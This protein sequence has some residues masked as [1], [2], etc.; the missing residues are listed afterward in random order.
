[1]GKYKTLTGVIGDEGVRE[2]PYGL[3]YPSGNSKDLR[4]YLKFFELLKE[5]IFII[6]NKFEILYSN[7]FFCNLSGYGK[8]EIAGKKLTELITADK[9][10]NKTEVL[11]YLTGY[12]MWNK[13]T[14]IRNKYGTL[15][16]V[17]LSFHSLYYRNRN[18]RL[19]FCVCTDT[20]ELKTAID[21]LN[22]RND[23]LDLLNDVI[24]QT[25]RSMDLK[26]S[27]TYAI[28][29]VCQYTMWE[30]G[31]CF[32]VVN[33]KLV[34]TGIWNSDLNRKYSAFKKY[35]ERESYIPEKGMPRKC[36]Q[37]AKPLLYD[38]NK[39]K[40]GYPFIRFDYIRKYGLISG[41]WLPVLINKKVTGV[42]E[43]FSSSHIGSDNEILYGLKN[44]CLELGNLKERIETINGIKINEKLAA[45]GR[46]S[47]GIAHEIRNPL[48]NISALS[49]LL[50]KNENNE[51][52]KLYLNYIFENIQIANNTITDLLSNVSS[53]ELLLSEVDIRNF[54]E[55]IL[56]KT[57]LRFYKRKIQVL[58][59]ISSVLPP[60]YIDEIKMENAIMNF[61]TNALDSMPSGGR[62]KFKVHK[63]KQE[64]N[65]AII[66]ADS[67]VGIP[68]EN[69]EKIFEPFFTTKHYGTGLGMG[70]ALQAIKSHG[71]SL[72]IKSKQG[73]GTTI[74]IKIPLMKEN[75]SE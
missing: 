70:L 11:R 61:L 44:I 34:S 30:I 26:S 75:K 43:F 72:K 23:L 58:K 18:Q 14:G 69:M 37:R 27:V 12:G 13:E 32:L 22:K 71:G 9:P 33:D 29:K 68:E 8:N 6:N 35:T 45:L 28:D 65:I 24:K 57:R 67:G 15:K 38:L 46:F 39:L 54:I 60:V 2:F 62:I 40:K 25:N 56:S 21:L 20:T 53:D 41:V 50:L 49:Q 66:I 17:G 52:K 1:M 74:E 10:L 16:Y 59:S 4:D 7:T 55:K 36:F 5:G 47:V 3:F 73:T 31:H 51:K 64:D 19:I 48:A 63:I 42:I